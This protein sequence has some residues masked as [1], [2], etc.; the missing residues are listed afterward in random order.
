MDNS[1]EMWHTLLSG[2]YDICLALVYLAEYESGPCGREREIQMAKDFIKSYEA[3]PRNEV[4][5]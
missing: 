4:K 3:D 1:K 2:I 5:K